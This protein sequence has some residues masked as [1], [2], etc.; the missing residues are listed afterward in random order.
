MKRKPFKF[1]HT[2]VVLLVVASCATVTDIRDIPIDQGR[3]AYYAYPPEDVFIAI[4]R[5]ISNY[6]DIKILETI[7]IR[8]STWLIIAEIPWSFYRGGPEYL[9]VIIEPHRAGT[10]VRVLSKWKPFTFAANPD[11][12]QYIFN[13]TSYFLSQPKETQSSSAKQESEEKPKDFSGPQAGDIKPRKA[14]LIEESK[15]DDFLQELVKNNP[16]SFV[17]KPYIG[18]YVIKNIK[19]DFE[20]AWVEEKSPAGRAGVQAG[21][22]IDSVDNLRFRDRMSLLEYFYERKK[23]GES[24]NAV[25]RRGGET[26]KMVAKLESI[27]FPRDQYALMQEVVRE[28]PL[29]LAIII[30]NISN[31]YL[32]GT[33]LEQ[34]INGM[35]PILITTLE[36]DL[37]GFLKYEKDT[38]IVDRFTLDKAVN[39]LALQQTGLIKEESLIK[40]GKML[41]ATHLIIVDF[42][43]FSLSPKEANDVQTRRLIQIESGKILA[44]IHIKTAVLLET[45]ISLLQQDL[46]IYKEQLSK[47]WPMLSR[48]MI[49]PPFRRG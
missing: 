10:M 30:G 3:A 32:Q 19:G 47:I 27:H 36:N 37:L 8:H 16:Q 22:I 33:N 38:S 14:E 42:S 28:K 6:G 21:D 41:G 9:R 12:S 20:V 1:Y 18:V 49:Y 24:L 25:L 40:V 7:E 4:R 11:H 31:V 29:N 26:L 45:A 44:S 17:K 34:W 2:I 46:L 13:A 43:R 39:E 23:P 35:K 5:T 48:I 15:H